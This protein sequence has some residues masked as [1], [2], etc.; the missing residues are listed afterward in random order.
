V[1][2]SSV[3][4]DPPTPFPREEA[5]RSYVAQLVCYTGSG[6]LSTAELSARRMG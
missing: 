3:M 5:S 2:S 1:V 6:I 4:A